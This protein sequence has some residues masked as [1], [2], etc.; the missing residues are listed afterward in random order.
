MRAEARNIVGHV[1]ARLV[2]GIWLGRRGVRMEAEGK[3]KGVLI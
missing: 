1:S 3:G 2:A